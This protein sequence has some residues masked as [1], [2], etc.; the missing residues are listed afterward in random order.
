MSSGAVSLRGLPTSILAFFGISPREA[1]SMDPQQRLLLEAAWEVLERAAIDPAAV[2]GTRTGVFIGAEPREYGPRP[3][4]GAGRPGRR[5]CSTGTTTS[6][7]SGR[8]A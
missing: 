3:L 1:T 7:M 5:I 2:K 8:I 6:V 4:R